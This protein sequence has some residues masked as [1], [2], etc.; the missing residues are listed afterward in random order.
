M[1]FFPQRISPMELSGIHL[2]DKNVEDVSLKTRDGVT[3]MGWMVK[4]PR[5]GKSPLIIYFGGNAEEV[6]YLI[7]ESDELRGWS[8]ALMN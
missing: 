2:R 6:S 8:L 1:I 7:G 4:D 3:I 5:T